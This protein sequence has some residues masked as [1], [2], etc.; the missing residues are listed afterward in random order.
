MYYI[1]MNLYD[2]NFQLNVDRQN[3][4]ETVELP[5]VLGKKL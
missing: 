4:I 2:L 1:I 5:L 3:N